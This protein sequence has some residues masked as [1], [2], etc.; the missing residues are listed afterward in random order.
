MVERST[1]I[2]PSA[3]YRLS[4]CP[5]FLIGAHKGRINRQLEVPELKNKINKDV[6]LDLSIR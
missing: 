5:E 6:A 2:S 4:D 3:D 1:K